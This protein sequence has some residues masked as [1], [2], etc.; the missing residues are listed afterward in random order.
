[1]KTPIGQ[2][3]GQENCTENLLN[4]Q[5]DDNI[6]PKNLPGI[7]NKFRIESYHH[8]KSKNNCEKYNYTA[9]SINIYYQLYYQT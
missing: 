4:S 3:P 5:K 6:K 8:I 7:K 9:D 1:M 2:I